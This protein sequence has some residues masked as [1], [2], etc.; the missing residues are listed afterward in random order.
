ML[1]VFKRNSSFS[2]SIPLEDF[3]SSLQE[4]EFGLVNER[5]TDIWT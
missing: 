3:L 5:L 1:I 2:Y 4:E